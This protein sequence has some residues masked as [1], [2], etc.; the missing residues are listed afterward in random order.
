ML[1]SQHLHRDLLI[2]RLSR[3]VR[4]YCCY[5]DCRHAR[6]DETPRQSGDIEV[7]RVRP[8]FRGDAAAA[9]IDA[10]SDAAWKRLGG[11]FDQ[12]C[13]IG[14]VRDGSGLEISG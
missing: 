8:A 3:Q 14:T 5:D 2:L 11:G 12:A 13:V 4:L 7:G 10:D 9:G 6:I 1:L